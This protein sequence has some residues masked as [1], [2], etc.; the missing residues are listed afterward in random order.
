MAETATPGWQRLLGIAGHVATVLMFLM[1]TA[2]SWGALQSTLGG[3]LQSL[4]STAGSYF[5]LANLVRVLQ[6]GVAGFAGYYLTR[7][8]RREM[9]VMQ[10]E[11]D[12]QWLDH[13]TSSSQTQASVAGVIE[14][15]K[16]RGMDVRRLYVENYL[17]RILLMGLAARADKAS[18]RNAIASRREVFQKG[19][20]NEDDKTIALDMISLYERTVDE[21]Y[22]EG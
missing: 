4:V 5:T 9:H 10:L 12:R 6:L 3:V 22:P 18:V 21:S 19:L 7:V 2:V 14:G 15:L 16:D 8:V 11:I 20:T 1:F 13:L 17:Q